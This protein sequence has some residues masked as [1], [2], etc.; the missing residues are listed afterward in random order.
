M[1][2]PTQNMDIPISWTGVLELL[3]ALLSTSCGSS[4]TSHLMLLPLCFPTMMS[5]T[6]GMWAKVHSSSLPY[7]TF[8]GHLVRDTWAV[9]F[10]KCSMDVLLEDTGAG[11]QALNFSLTFYL[12]DLPSS[13]QTQPP[14]TWR[15]RITNKEHKVSRQPLAHSRNAVDSSRCS[16]CS[17]IINSRL[18]SSE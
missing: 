10:M 16:R 1:G 14:S 2:R 17:V 15:A 7:I 5:S 18:V 13:S 3:C 9:E 12:G 11:S 4:V 6:I 8:S